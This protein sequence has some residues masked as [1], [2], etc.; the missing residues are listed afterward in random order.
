MSSTCP[1]CQATLRGQILRCLS[2][3]V[4]LPSPDLAPSFSPPTPPHITVQ[5][6]RSQHPHPNPSSKLEFRLVDQ[7]DKCTDKLPRVP[8]IDPRRHYAALQTLLSHMTS[9]LPLLLEQP[10]QMPLAKKSCH[11]AVLTDQSTSPSLPHIRC[12][13]PP[14]YHEEPRG[15]RVTIFTS[16]QA[17]DA[18]SPTKILSNPCNRSIRCIQLLLPSSLSS[19]SI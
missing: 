8:S 17:H 14:T 1:N 15:H 11:Q 4:A 6:S 16:I 2:G 3:A 12:Q 13:S 10:N 9:V 18:Q 5:P 7:A 19:S